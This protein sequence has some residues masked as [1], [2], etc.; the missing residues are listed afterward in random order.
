MPIDIFSTAKTIVMLVIDR[1]E[2]M[3]ISDDTMK[4]IIENLKWIEQTI[5]NIEPYFKSDSDTKVI[6][7]FDNNLQNINELCNQIFEK[8]V[9]E[10]FSLAESILDQLKH[11]E[12]QVKLAYSQLQLFLETNN[13]IRLNE[14]TKK[15]ISRKSF[16]LQENF[17]TGLT[18]VKN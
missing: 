6:K 18:I 8:D 5:K 9:I 13:F 1:L 7:E 10:K 16:I 3:G 4:K 12:A 17:E 2:K 15:E 14:A 11:L